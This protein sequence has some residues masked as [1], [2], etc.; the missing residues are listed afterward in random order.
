VDIAEGDEA[1]EIKN[2]IVLNDIIIKI[3]DED[4]SIKVVLNKIVDIAEGDKALEIKN[5]IVLNDIIIK[6]RDEDHSI[7]EVLNKIVEMAEE[8]EEAEEIMKTLI[9]RKILIK[10]SKNLKNIKKIR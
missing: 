6:I 1:L 4:H 10:I 7:K 3:R 2:K 5:K 8:E 9:F